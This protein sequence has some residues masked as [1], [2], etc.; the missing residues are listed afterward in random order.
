ML[1]FNINLL[2]WGTNFVCT[3]LPGNKLYAG[4]AYGTAEGFSSIAC[5]LI[6]KKV[7]PGIVMQVCAYI[8]PICTAI[9]YIFCASTNTGPLAFALNFLSVFAVGSQYCAFFLIV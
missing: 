4:L 5:G 6:T 9:F 3:S 1:M 7:D 8:M 2:Y